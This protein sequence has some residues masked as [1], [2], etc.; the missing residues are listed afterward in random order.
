MN[1]RMKIAAMVAAAA[2]LLAGC[3]TPVGEQTNAGVAGHG[4]TYVEVETPA[5]PVPCLIYD[6]YRAGGL[7]CDWE[8][9]R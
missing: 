5:G 7:D 2:L 6:S 4:V 3:A 9:T 8:A 1:K